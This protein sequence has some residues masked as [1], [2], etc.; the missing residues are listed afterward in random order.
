MPL[1]IYV[2]KLIKYMPFKKIAFYIFTL[3]FHPNLKNN[4]EIY[5]SIK[6]G[7][8]IFKNHL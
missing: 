2:R 1:A 8:N 6:T 5:E 4:N 3:V 7:I